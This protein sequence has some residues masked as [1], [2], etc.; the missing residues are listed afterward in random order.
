MSQIKRLFTPITIN[1]MVLKNRIVMSPIY[2]G[3]A[4]GSGEVT[5]RLIRYY[6]ERALG[7][8]GLIVIEFTTI[9]PLGGAF[10]NMLSIYDDRVIPGLKRLTNAV[11]KAGAKIAMQIAHSG[12]RT[13][14]TLIGAQPVAPSA[15]PQPGGEIPREL[16]GKEI[17]DLVQAFGRGAHRVKESGFDAV[18]I[19]MAHGYLIQQFLSPLSNKRTDAYGGDFTNRTR[20]ALEVLDQVRKEVGPKFPILSRIVGDEF[21]MGGITLK[22]AKELA[23]LLE[24]QG[25]DAIN[26]SGGSGMSHQM[27]VQPTAVPRG[28]LVPLAAGIKKVV[29]I[30]VAAVGRLTPALGEQILKEQK[31]DL[32]VIGRG[33]IADPEA[34]RKAKEGR[35]REIRPCIACHQG[36]TDRIWKH[37]PVSCL[38]NPKV[39]REA[40]YP[41]DRAK[42]PK[43]VMIIGGGPAGLEA[44]IV[45]AERGHRVILYEKERLG[46]QLTMASM[47][48]GKKDLQELREAFIFLMK[49]NKVKVKIKNADQRAIEREKPDVLIVAT[50]AV[51]L[52]PKLPGVNGTHAVTAWDALRGDC[53]IGERV[54]IVGGGQV[55]CE[56]ASFLAE[57]GCR[58]TLIE[59]MKDIAV[60][61]PN[62]PKKVLLDTLSEK[63]VEIRTMSEL[64]EI[65]NK[66]VIFN[67]S[68]VIERI[69]GVDNVVLA[70]GAQ[71]QGFP[72]EKAFLKG[73]KVFFIGDCVKPRKAF[74]AIHE[75][76]EVGYQI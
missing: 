34:P 14:S 39:G 58:V 38:V 72:V 70:T 60:D 20:F 54:V 61:M 62:T 35:I 6:V 57:K 5:D 22:E 7:R 44:A 66:E 47:P 26:V 49:K 46:G 24:R 68:G 19:H 71:L 3:Y 74:D 4:T 33:L 65:R 51:P 36:C 76:F 27:I 56:T 11:H 48:P 50:G 59:M 41:I 64:K 23:K 43:K 1:G 25:V 45:S 2:T 42:K 16:T 30:P 10:P 21:V 28:V 12:R 18:M 37:L 40:D 32:I 31:A 17:A 53:K 75:G 73:T 69:K 8:T 63:G 55:G 13:H 15:I 9:D 29:R 52:V 67:R